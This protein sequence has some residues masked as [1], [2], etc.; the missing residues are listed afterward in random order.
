MDLRDTNMSSLTLAPSFGSSASFSCVNESITFG[1]NYS[2]VLPQGIN[3]MKMS[4]NLKFNDLDDDLVLDLLSF[5]Q[6]QF[7][8]KLQD[9]NDLGHF[10]NKRIEPFD[11]EPFYPYKSNKF[12]C[13]NYNHQKE[14]FNVNS[15]SAI[16]NAISPSMLQSAES[17]MST[18]D[19]QSSN[20]TD[21]I[22]DATFTNTSSE[23]IFL[24]KYS[25]LYTPHSYNSYKVLS[26]SETIAP[27]QSVNIKLDNPNQNFENYQNGLTN[28]TNKRNSIFIKDIH[29]CSYFPYAPLHI[30]GGLNLKMFDFRADY[31]INLNHSPKYK[32]SNVSDLY[33]KYNLYGFNPNL[34]NLQLKFTGRSNIEAKR[35]LLFLES[36]LGYKKFGFHIQ[37]DY[38][39]NRSSSDTRHTTPHR[40]NISFY[41]C[42][43][44]T[45]TLTYFNSHDITATFIE[46]PMV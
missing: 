8:Y 30:T 40:K 3:S 9:Y 22:I 29:D 12:N 14:H 28:Q 18:Y 39:A 20:P 1:D 43:E 17:F 27:S 21:R 4:M 10:N 23:T 16:F 34:F 25:Y 26:G 13:F 24:T 36:H 6:G 37:K 15:I 46:C 41:Y 7:Y 42:P 44:W 5:L 33:A 45:H 32:K 31:Q 19:L 11:F 2:Q 35:I 38:N